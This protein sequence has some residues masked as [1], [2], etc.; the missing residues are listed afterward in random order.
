MSLYDHTEIK[1][2]VG[3]IWE[4]VFFSSNKILSQSKKC[5]FAVMKVIPNPNI[6]DMLVSLQIFSFQMDR[7]VDNIEILGIDYDDVRLVLNAREQLRKLQRVATALLDDNE[8]DYNVA[9][10]ELDKQAV[11]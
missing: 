5:A 11:F 6:H 4:E 3:K 1:D 2:R 10:E 7:I 8:H 9:I